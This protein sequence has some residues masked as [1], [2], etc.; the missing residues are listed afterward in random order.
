MCKALTLPKLIALLAYGSIGYLALPVFLFLYG[1]TWPVVSLLAGGTLLMAVIATG[2]Q[3]ARVLREIPGKDV[4]FRATGTNVPGYLPGGACLPPLVLTTILVLTVILLWGVG[5]YGPQDSDYPKHNA[6]LRALIENPWPVFVDSDRGKFP[7]VFY[8]AYYLPAA[9]V[10][11]ILGWEAAHHFLQL[12]ST[13]GLLLSLGWFGLV[14][15]R[16]SW[17]VPAVFFFFSGWDVVGAA[18]VRSWQGLKES[19]LEWSLF[20]LGHIDWAALRWWNWQ[21]RWWDIE[22][23]RNYPNPIEQLFFVPHQALAGW[24]V[25]GILSFTGSV[26][27]QKALAL[28]GAFC[29]LLALWSPLALIG[30]IPL[31]MWLIIEAYRIH[32][33]G[34]GLVQALFSPVNILALPGFIVVFLY[35]LAR[36]GPLPFA[37]A[38]ETSFG[39]GHPEWS[40]LHFLIRIALF[41]V[42]EIAIV[43]SLIAWMKPFGSGVEA[44]LFLASFGWLAMLPLFRYG[45]CNDLVMRASLPG[46][47]LLAA[48]F[49][50][51]LAS[52]EIP[53]VRRL[54]LFGALLIGATAPFSDLYAHFRE[55]LRRGRLVEIPEQSA[56]WSL[57]EL[58]EW[59]AQNAASTT[60]PLVRMFRDHTFFVQYVGSPETLFFR[61]MARNSDLESPAKNHSP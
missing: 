25:T 53:R 40:W 57:W 8:V 27:P 32:H 48:W 49:A 46:L 51:A 41:V 11:K 20:G 18:I 35:Y 34:S 10:G 39:I 50:R 55:A 9:W 31:V 26:A 38:A 13:F 5:G 56:V 54:I 7:L 1:W 17:S 33:R 37:S 16:Y 4:L 15:G 59:S 29:T 30:L 28:L 36:F 12:W 23:A 43:A 52:P 58:N 44:R 24:V 47:F 19:G 21:V 60:H 22:L 42:V 6:I 45:A 2:K 61:F 14:V 3:M